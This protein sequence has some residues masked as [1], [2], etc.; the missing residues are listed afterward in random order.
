MIQVFCN[1]S[2]LKKVRFT[3]LVGFALTSLTALAFDNANRSNTCDTTSEHEKIFVN[4][5][6]WPRFPGGE[7]ALMQFI[8]DNIHYPP[9]AAKKRIEGRVL[10]RFVVDSIGQVRDVEVVRSLNKA[11]DREAVRLV[12]SLPRFIP[13]SVYGEPVN[14]NYVLPVTFKLNDG[15]DFEALDEE[16]EQRP[17]FPGGKEALMDFLRSNVRYPDEAARRRVEGVVY[18]QF[19]VDRNGKISDIQVVG[20]V[21]NTLDQEAV[22]VCKLLPDFEPALLHGEPVDEHFI[23]A[24]TFEI[25][26]YGKTLFGK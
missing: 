22:R 2:L 25:I 6:S 11:L 9:E 18:V 8:Q 1:I 12:Q 16:P 23:L 24:I 10:V 20:P 17:Q 13:G 5:E 7:D 4:P 3:V 26:R 14:M 15:M 19:M 21:D